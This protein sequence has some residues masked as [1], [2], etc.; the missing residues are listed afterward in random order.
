VAWTTILAIYFLIWWTVLFAVLPWG[1]KSQHETGEI[2]PGTDPGA[3]TITGFKSKLI[4][5]TILATVVFAVFYGV[6]VTRLVTLEDLG[7]LWGLIG[8]RRS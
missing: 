2:A 1:I 3:P 7:T 8:E 6:Y 4:W 5:T